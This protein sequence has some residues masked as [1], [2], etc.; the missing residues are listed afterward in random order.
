MDSLINVMQLVHTLLVLLSAPGFV[1][2]FYIYI[3]TDAENTD[4][5]RHEHTCHRNGS[6]SDTLTV[7]DPVLSVSVQFVLCRALGCCLE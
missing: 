3:F 5:A 4:S 1:V 7:I 6:I 2:D